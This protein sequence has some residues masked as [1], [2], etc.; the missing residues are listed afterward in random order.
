MKTPC[1]VLP[2]G[3][4]GFGFC[5]FSLNVGWTMYLFHLYFPN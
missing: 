3:L 1:F 2:E 4:G 5:V